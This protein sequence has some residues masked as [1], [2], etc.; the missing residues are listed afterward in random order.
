MVDVFE[1][2]QFKAG[3]LQTALAVP[4]GAE[5][6]PRS[7]GPFAV[8]AH[9]LPFET[10]PGALPMDFDVRPH[11]HLG[12][13]A[14]SYVLDGHITH[15]DSLGHRSEVGPGGVHWMIAGRGAVHS[16]RFERMRLLGGKLD[17]LQILLALPDG[18]EEMEPT[19]AHVPASAL[20]E[21]S[22]GGATIRALAGAPNGAADAVEFPAA[23]HLHDVRLEPGGRYASPEGT[24][25]RGIYV[26][27]GAIQIDGRAVKAQQTALLAPGSAVVLATERARVLAFGGEPVGPRFMWWNFIHSSLERIE[28]AKAAW[29]AGESPLP[30]GDTESFT[31]A[32]PDDGRP[33]LRLNA[34]A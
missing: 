29:R 2:R 26:L 11:P 6:A 24:T 25:E 15:R 13:A 9:A 1:A 18:F 20:P 32:P 31:P 8:V 7:V 19:F 27:E 14:A 16:E 3:E 23:I 4:F 21:V 30:P 5:G 22:D 12:L 17:M 33:L 28:E 34:P 10:A